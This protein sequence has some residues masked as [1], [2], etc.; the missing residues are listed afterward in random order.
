MPKLLRIGVHRLKQARAAVGALLT[1]A[2]RQAIAMN[3][4]MVVSGNLSDANAT[5]AKSSDLSKNFDL[6][7]AGLGISLSQ[8]ISAIKIVN[9]NGRGQFKLQLQFGTD[10]APAS[11]WIVAVSMA[12]ETL[13]LNQIQSFESTLKAF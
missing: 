10:S 4:P 9:N 2:D 6:S 1:T 7:N 11:I 3:I 5:V 12:K 13:T 8:N